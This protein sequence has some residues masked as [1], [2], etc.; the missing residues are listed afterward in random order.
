L[1]SHKRR[2]IILIVIN[3]MGQ[4]GLIKIL[5]I[6]LVVILIGIA[7]YFLFIQRTPS[8]VSLQDL[9]AAPEKVEI[10]GSEYTL[11]TDLWRDF[12]PVSP[13]DG[14]PLMALVKIKA[15]GETAI[16]SKIDAT[17]LWVVK[18]EEIWETE[19]TSEEFSTTGDTLE[20]VARDGP[21]WGPEITVD[22]VVKI[23]VKILGSKSGKSYLLKASNQ[24]I[25]RTM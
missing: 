12:M 20:K 24:Y 19:F 22:V 3:H 2:K 9:R 10:N 21:K 11:E 5:L 17:R 18:D 25:H 13:P 15:A 1:F 6:C 23:V 8:T 16:S 4:K 7:T 14:S